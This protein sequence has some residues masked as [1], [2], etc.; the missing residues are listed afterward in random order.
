MRIAR[1]PALAAACLM[2]A[3]CGFQP[4][5]GTFDDGSSVA[6]QLASVSIPEQKTRVG[7]LIRNELLAS[8]APAGSESGNAYTL[9]L[10]PE[11]SEETAIEAFTTEV[12]RRAYRVNV[13]FRLHESASGKLLYAGKS[14]S[15]VSYDRTGTPFANLQARIN[16]EERAAKEV[17][18]DIRTR[19]AAFF[20][21]R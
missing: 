8:I 11:A 21:T 20:A 6:V 18:T 1:R 14:F 12:L 7:Q 19:I 5:Y 17:G 16:A 10:Q 9:E 15:Q 2:L 4:L 3:G 13:D